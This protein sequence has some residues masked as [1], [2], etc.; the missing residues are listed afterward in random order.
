MSGSLSRTASLAG[1][2]P[3]PYLGIDPGAASVAA[4]LGSLAHISSR[5]AAHSSSPQDVNSHMIQ[6]SIPLF[7]SRP[8]L[9]VT[10]G[11]MNFMRQRVGIEI[12]TAF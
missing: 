3:G 4:G 10:D 9:R 6:P 2:V 5:A 12:L 7:V 8:P 1:S 11:V